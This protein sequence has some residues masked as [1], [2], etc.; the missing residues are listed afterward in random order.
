MLSF[1]EAF[2]IMALMFLAML[3]FV[4]MLRRPI[5]HAEPAGTGTAEPK[6]QERA[7]ARREEEKLKE[8]EEEEAYELVTH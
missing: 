6:S 1:V 3:P 7:P 5:H 2:W 4:F 8:G